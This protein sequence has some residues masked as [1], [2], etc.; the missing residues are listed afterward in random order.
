MKNSSYTSMETSLKS[1]LTISRLSLLLVHIHSHLQPESKDGCYTCNSLSISIR[2]ISGKENA[3]NVLSRLAIDSAPDAAIKQ[4]EEY[5]RSII[6][7]AISAA[8]S[9][10]LVE[11][12]SERYP[13]L[14]LVRHAITSDDWTKL[15]GTTY[16]AIRDEL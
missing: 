4:T 3:A 6:A 16:R 5:T 12:E 10:H 9:P 15:Q 13:T 8:L 14:Q 2:H 7:D 11:R 1:A